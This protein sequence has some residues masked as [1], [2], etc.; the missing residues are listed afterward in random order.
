LPEPNLL[1]TPLGQL[2]KDILY[3]STMG[4]SYGYNLFLGCTELL[5]GVLLFF[6]KTR[7]IGALAAVFICANIVAV[8]FSF[9]ISVKLLSSFLLLLSLFIAI[10]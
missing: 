5:T 4:S 2:D 6:R 7:A 3:W 8:N 1:F 9:D 10:P